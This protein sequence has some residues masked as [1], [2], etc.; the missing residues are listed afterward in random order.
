MSCAST[1]VPLVALSLVTLVVAAKTHGRQ[2]RLER[3]RA[4]YHR[5]V[6][7]GDNPAF[8]VA[9]WRRDRVRLWTSALVLALA[10]IVVLATRGW[11]LGGLATAWLLVVLPL[12]GG[13]IVSGGASGLALLRADPAFA[14]GALAGSLGWWSLLLALLSATACTACM[15]C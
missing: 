14:R 8:V 12:L 4:G 1:S 7:G 2:I 5:V 9:L 11:P 13:F 6:F 3:E 10:A 15:C